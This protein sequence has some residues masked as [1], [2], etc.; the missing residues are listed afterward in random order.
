MAVYAVGDVQG[1]KDELLGLLDRLRF[2][3]SRD[4]LWFAGD[5]VNRGPDSLGSLRLVRD[6]GDAA[7]TVLGN[8][9]LHLLAVAG[10]HGKGRHEPDIQQV[11][12]APDRDELLDWLLRRPLLHTD[13]DLGWTMV[14]AGLPPQWDLDTAINCAREVEAAL[15]A[16]A[17]AVF[18]SMYGNKPDRWSASL[19]G[20]DRLRF[21][22]NC[23][24]RLR[25]VDA[26]GSVLLKLKTAPDDA[27][28][29]AIPWFRHPARAT[30]G[31]RIV[32]G[33][34]STLGLL[35]EDAIICL[36]GGC[37]WGGSLCATRLD[38]ETAP[39]I[40]DCAGHRRPG[41]D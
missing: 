24:T 8:H 4:R 30:A 7:I 10:G 40:Y 34:W 13:P 11:L 25:Y 14:H 19:S 9:D 18:A 22:V 39:V 17:A 6:L 5:L 23:M 16:D 36:D 28:E 29:G 12:T 38:R 37:V 1:C 41:A 33:H 26:A 27:P 20:S 3:P 2:D 31:E 32:F 15:E 35:Q 21:I